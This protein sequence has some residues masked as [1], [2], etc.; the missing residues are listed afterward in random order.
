MLNILLENWTKVGRS[1]WKRRDHHAPS[2][3]GRRWWTRVGGKRQ[4]CL[5]V[6]PLLGFTFKTQAVPQGRKGPVLELRQICKSGEYRTGWHQTPLPPV[7]RLGSL[8]RAAPPGQEGAGP[9]CRPSARLQE[10]L[11]G[12][13]M[14]LILF[15]GDKEESTWKAAIVQ[16][17]D[18]FSQPGRSAQICHPHSHL[19][20]R[21]VRSC[22]WRGEPFQELDLWSPLLS[23]R[24]LAHLYRSRS[25]VFLKS[26]LCLTSQ[27]V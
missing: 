1:P 6:L 17:A 12:G 25:S 20:R 14:R 26:Q 23:H 5:F 13:R 22:S 15:Q 8:L 11:L 27:T 24:V 10:L 9:G 18:G 2:R 3:L 4:T 7:W 16:E 19:P 21:E